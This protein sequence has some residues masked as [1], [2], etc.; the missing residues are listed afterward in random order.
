MVHP[1]NAR[2]PLISTVAIPILKKVTCF[3]SLRAMDRSDLMDPRYLPARAGINGNLNEPRTLAYVLVTS[4]DITALAE[5]GSGGTSVSLSM[6]THTFGRG[7]DGD[8][9]RFKNLVAGLEVAL[10]DVPT[11]LQGVLAHQS[12]PMM[13]VGLDYLVCAYRDINSNP[14]V[15]DDGAPVVEP[16][17]DP[18]FAELLAH[19]P[20]SR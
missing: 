5:P 20:R 6:S 8:K 15:I 1:I 17:A 4:A 14:A 19:H 12:I 16:G 9:R 11:S 13:L 18:R 7:V 10:T 3:L 2:A